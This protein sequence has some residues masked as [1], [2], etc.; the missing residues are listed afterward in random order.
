VRVWRGIVVFGSLGGCYGGAYGGSILVVCAMVK[1]G[2]GAW[3][4][5]IGAGG[6]GGTDGERRRNL[7]K[8]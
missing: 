8:G 2:G 3:L 7:A 5:C 1:R 6:L 4:W